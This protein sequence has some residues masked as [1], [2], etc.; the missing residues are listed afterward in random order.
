MIAARTQTPPQHQL[1]ET[2]LYGALTVRNGLS[3]MNGKQQAA[4]REE[5]NEVNDKRMPPDQIAKIE[6]PHVLRL[7]KAINEFVTEL[8]QTPPGSLFCGGINRLAETLREIPV[9]KRDSERIYFLILL[10]LAYWLVW[11]TW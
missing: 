6:P 8:K 10:G 1:S 2:P 3:C 9:T 7:R 11:S 5:E 4:A